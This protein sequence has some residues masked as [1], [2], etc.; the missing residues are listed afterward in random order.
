MTSRVSDL[1]SDSDL[2]SI[3]NSCDIY[4]TTK[5]QSFPLKGPF[6]KSVT[7]GLDLIYCHVMN[8]DTENLCLKFNP[9][10]LPGQS[11]SISISVSVFV[12]VFGSG[13]VHIQCSVINPL[14]SWHPQPPPPLKLRHLQVVSYNFFIYISQIYIFIQCNA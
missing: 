8:C 1:Q 2:D 5:Q 13:L 14:S 9:G 4:K 12:F 10:E 7:N 11:V 3:C 6:I